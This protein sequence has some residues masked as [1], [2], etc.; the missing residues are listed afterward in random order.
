MRSRRRELGIAL[1]IVAGITA[2]SALLG[3][4][5]ELAIPLTASKRLL[6]ELVEELAYNPDNPYSAFAPA[7]VSAVVWDFRGLDTL[8]ETIVFIAATI[9]ALNLYHEY[10]GEAELSRHRLSVILQSTAKIQ[11]VMATAVSASLVA[12]GHITP[13]G[14]FQ[15]GALLAAVVIAATTIYSLKSLVGRF[16]KHELILCLLGLATLLLLI[17]SSKWAIVGFF[18]GAPGYILQNQAKPGSLHGFLFWDGE[19]WVSGSILVYDLIEYIVI[20]CG[21]I[22]LLLV[23]IIGGYRERVI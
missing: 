22:V 9:F 15:G 2:L 23:V 14:G 19:H 11:I 21:L 17:A 18:T 4:M 16:I 8:Y 10:L 12:R 6:K 3:L 5:G 1:L 20:A 13:G 7:Y